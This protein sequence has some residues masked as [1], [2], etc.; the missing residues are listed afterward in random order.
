MRRSLQPQHAYGF[1]I[2]LCGSCLARG[3]CSS[4]KEGASATTSAKSITSR[5][6][7]AVSP[8]S[9]R[10]SS[11][12]SPRPTSTA[13]KSLAGRTVIGGGARRLR[14][15]VSRQVGVAGRVVYRNRGRSHGCRVVRAVRHEGGRRLGRLIG[16]ATRY[17]ALSTAVAGDSQ[18]HNRGRLG[19]GLCEGFTAVS[20]LGAG[21]DHV[22]EQGSGRPPPFAVNRS[23]EH[24]SRSRRP[25][26][27]SSAP[28][29]ATNCGTVRNRP[30]RSI[31]A[32]SPRTVKRTTS[33]KR[34]SSAVSLPAPATTRSAQ[35]S[36][37]SCFWSREGFKV[38][39]YGTLGEREARPDEIVERWRDHT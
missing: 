15:F 17:S 32:L 35:T 13:P 6:P 10:R 9:S 39:A 33:Q 8:S 38:G 31:A 5:S 24:A 12:A 2:R 23:A 36:S 7:E 16:V 21:A 22:V 3:Y 19:T 1:P 20:R 26:V 14:H 11:A 29:G 30:R 18:R 25:I 28:T 34:R 27:W 4:A 37:I